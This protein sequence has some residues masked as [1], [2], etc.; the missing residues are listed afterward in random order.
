MLKTTT[1]SVVRTAGPADYEECWRLFMQGHKE[2]GLFS[3]DPQKVQWLLNRLLFPQAILPQDTGPRGIVGVIG[4]VGN[5]EGLTFVVIREYWYSSE[6]YISECMVFVDPECRG[7]GHAVALVDWLKEQSEAT[8]LPVLASVLS[9]HRT[10]AKC[11][12][13][14]RSLTKVGEIFMV[15]PVT[16][17]MASS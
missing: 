11:R 17:A 4:E 3:I 9:T 13:Y 8:G 14:R 5:L 16:A 12:L 1:P 7:T 10:E 2:N 15:K 6:K